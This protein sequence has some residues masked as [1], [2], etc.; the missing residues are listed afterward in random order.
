MVRVLLELTCTPSLS[1][2][3]QLCRV[4]G[5]PDPCQM[6]PRTYPQLHGHDGHE[7]DDVQIPEKVLGWADEFMVFYLKWD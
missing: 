6:F 7:H 4:P 3:A 1:V 5:F 2:L